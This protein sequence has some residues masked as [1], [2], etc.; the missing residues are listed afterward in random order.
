MTLLLAV[1]GAT[2]GRSA[3]TRV[4]GALAL[5]AAGH[6]LLHFGS[7]FVYILFFSN[8]GS[9]NVTTMVTIHAIVQTAM[10]GTLLV[11]STLFARWRFRRLWRGAG[12]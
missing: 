4:A 1:A 6:L 9:Q 11:V 8:A 3:A 12:E 10:V 2:F 7:H 5:S